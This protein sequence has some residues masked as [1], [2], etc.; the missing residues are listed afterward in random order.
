MI[1]IPICGRRV[2][3]E[4]NA[5]EKLVIGMFRLWKSLRADRLAT[6]PELHLRLAPVGGAMLTVPLD[7]FF[8]QVSR[9]KSRPH[10]LKSRYSDQ[11]TCEE[12]MTVNLLQ[13]ANERTIEL[14][15][16]GAEWSAARLLALSASILQHL[17]SSELGHSFG[18]WL[19]LNSPGEYG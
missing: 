2:Q 7:D 11:L 6:L 19:S 16:M 1:H 9:W 10:N 5:S 18:S 13:T 8:M 15:S 14:R 12:V 4:L 17:F 3:N